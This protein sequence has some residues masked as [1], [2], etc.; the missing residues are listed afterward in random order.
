MWILQRHLGPTLHLWN[1]SQEAHVRN[2]MELPRFKHVQTNKSQI[3][4]GIAE[5]VRKVQPK[6]PAGSFG[7][8]F[9]GLLLLHLRMDSH[10]GGSAISPQVFKKPTKKHHPNHLK[11]NE[12]TDLLPTTLANQPT[13]CYRWP[14][15]PAAPLCTDLC[16]VRSS[17]RLPGHGENRPGRL[18]GTF[19]EN[20]PGR[21]FLFCSLG[22]R[23]W[24]IGKVH[25]N[26][27]NQMVSRQ[28]WASM[29]SPKLQQL[30][31]IAR[32]VSAF[33]CF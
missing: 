30:Q 21:F 8:T 2:C 3:T 19:T 25:Q 12:S 10:M 23:P 27:Q 18:V 17:G 4:S 15:T 11:K 22:K 14:T 5:L 9:S 24:W 7:A 32:S 33:W 13:N 26:H 28:F 29:K 1:I 31:W 16:F 6:R 20:S